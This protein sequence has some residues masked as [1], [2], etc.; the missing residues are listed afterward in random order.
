MYFLRIEIVRVPRFGGRQTVRFGQLIQG[1]R[2]EGHAVQKDKVLR[3]HAHYIQA[4]HNQFRFP[5]A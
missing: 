1:T 5:F 4:V 2:E 3:L